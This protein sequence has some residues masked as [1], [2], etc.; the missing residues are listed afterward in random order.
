MDIRIRTIVK[1]SVKIG[2]I[3]VKSIRKYLIYILVKPCGSALPEKGA[4]F[5]NDQ[6]IKIVLKSENLTN[7]RSKFVVSR[8]CGVLSKEKFIKMAWEA[9]HLDS[10]RTRILHWFKKVDQECVQNLGES[11]RRESTRSGDLVLKR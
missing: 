7:A 1:Q 3:H 10:L 8:I 2:A 11:T 5:S 4:Q 6:N 9:K